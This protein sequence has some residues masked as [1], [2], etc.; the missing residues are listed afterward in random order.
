[1]FHFD[2]SN[3]VEL[4]HFRTE[5]EV[6]SKKARFDSNTT[7]A[8]QMLGTFTF[9][10]S[11]SLLTRSCYVQKQA[12]NRYFYNTNTLRW[13]RADGMHLSYRGNHARTTHAVH[14]SA[15]TQTMGRTSHRL[16]LISTLFISF[17][18]SLSYNLGEDHL[19]P[20]YRKESLKSRAR[21]EAPQ[22]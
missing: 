16:A 18:P 9:G 4:P 12:M 17:T 20:S 21:G 5:V 3:C 8:V 22:S 1:M 15:Y 2:L 14:I 11:S 19:Y 6:T 13:D 10:M 7:W